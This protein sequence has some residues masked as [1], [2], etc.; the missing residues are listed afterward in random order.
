MKVL[1]WWMAS[2]TSLLLL[3]ACGA[4]EDPDAAN[5]NAPTEAFIAAEQ[6]KVIHDLE[7]PLREN[8]K[9]ETAEAK[10]VYDV[11]LAYAAEHPLDTITPEYLFRA[12][13][14]STGLKKNERAIKLYDRIIRNYPGW[15][16]LPET[17]FMKAFT[18]EN[19]M[20]QKGAAKQAYEDLIYAVPDHDLSAQAR[21]LIDNMQYSDE[22]LIK[23]W[24]KEAEE[25]G[26][27][28]G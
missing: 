24:K 4:S 6:Q 22:E 2:S 3:A 16:K 1:N 25:K 9:F 20:D 11:Y 14:V 8:L 15:Q 19:H 21:Q 17:Y 27:E 12:A 26:E 28:E 7:K 13:Q 18:Y 23:K 5:E 10:K